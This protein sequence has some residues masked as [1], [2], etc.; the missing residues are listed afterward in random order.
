MQINLTGHARRGRQFYIAFCHQ[1]PIT[2]SGETVD[3]A[4]E[5]V[6][7]AALSYLSAVRSV[8]PSRFEMLLKNIMSDDADGAVEEDAEPFSTPMPEAPMRALAYGVVD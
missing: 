5:R 8:D 3:E 7:D 1:L 4:V 2:T 6:P